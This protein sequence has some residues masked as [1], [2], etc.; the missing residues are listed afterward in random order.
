MRIVNPAAMAAAMMSLTTALGSTDVTIGKGHHSVNS[1]KYQHRSKH[2]PH[3]GK[4]EIARRKARMEAQ[5]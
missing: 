4:R 1:A 2:D 5:A 3:Q